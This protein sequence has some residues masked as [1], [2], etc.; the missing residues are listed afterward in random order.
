MEVD[1]DD[2]CEVMRELELKS[3]ISPSQ[4]HLYNT[5]NEVDDDI[6]DHTHEPAQGKQPCKGRKGKKRKHKRDRQR[7]HKTTIR[8][9]D[10][11]IT[12][13]DSLN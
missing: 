10:I 1:Y 9:E 7:L 13:E 8:T 11:D 2:R 3:T 5:Y 12:Q 4:N 6:M